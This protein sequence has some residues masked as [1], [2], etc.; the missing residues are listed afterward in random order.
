VRVEFSKQNLSDLKFFLSYKGLAGT[1][2]T[3]EE[4]SRVFLMSPTSNAPAMPDQALLRWSENPNNPSREQ[5]VEIVQTRAGETLIRSAMKLGE[6]IRVYLIKNGY[7]RIGVVKSCCEDRG[8]F[9]VRIE[10]SATGP[11]SPEYFSD[12]GPLVVEDFIT[13]EQEAQI[14]KDL[15]S[16]ASKLSRLSMG[17]ELGDARRAMADLQHLIRGISRSTAATAR[18]AWRQFL[19]VC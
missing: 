11:L 18:R 17:A 14:L 1:Y 16:G 9:L 10:M 5:T 7:T 12:P 6:N 15:E 19:P 13:E 3:I 4:S 2:V 8:G